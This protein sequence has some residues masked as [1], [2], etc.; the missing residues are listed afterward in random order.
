MCYEGENYIEI[1]KRDKYK[2]ETGQHI[3]D[4][5]SMIKPIGTDIAVLELGAGGD[6][7]FCRLLSLEQKF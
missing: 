5:V 3:F 2:I 1:Y 4:E 6:G 7:T